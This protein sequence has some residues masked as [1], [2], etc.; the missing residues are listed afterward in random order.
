VFIIYLFINQLN[1]RKMEDLEKRVAKIE[2]FI[3]GAAQLAGGIQPPAPAPTAAPTQKPAAS[4]PAT[5]PT[6]TP[7]TTPTPTPTPTPGPDTTP[8]PTPYC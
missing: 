5:G 8:T 2:A 4:K 7:G 6:P 1:F 3:A